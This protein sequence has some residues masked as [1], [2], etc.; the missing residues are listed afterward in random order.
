MTQYNDYNKKEKLT[1]CNPIVVKSYLHCYNM[2]DIILGKKY[3]FVFKD[4][5]Q[6]KGAK[7]GT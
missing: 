6:K 5:M 2:L 7:C 3:T 4:K 1:F